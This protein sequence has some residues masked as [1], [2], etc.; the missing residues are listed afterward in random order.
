MEEPREYYQIKAED[1]E[2]VKEFRKRQRDGKISYVKVKSYNLL[3]FVLN[4]DD[5][6]FLMGVTK[7][8]LWLKVY[9]TW[10]LGHS[11]N[12][13]RE[14]KKALRE[15]HIQREYLM[16][17]HHQHRAREARR[18]REGGFPR[19]RPGARDRRRRRRREGGG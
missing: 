1:I 16:P 17:S 15:L 2:K 12:S 19:Y 11:F 8:E 5:R 18:Y 7:R 14:A 3:R 10:Y 9:K 4:R 6:F 13:N